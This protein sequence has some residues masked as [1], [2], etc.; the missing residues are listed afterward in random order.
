[1]DNHVH[2]QW[3]W[4]A[5]P[6]ASMVRSCE[7]ALAAGLPAVAFTDHLD[8]TV[9]AEGDRIAAEHISPR[10]Y[11]RMRLLDVPGYLAAVQECRERFGDLRILSGAEIG[12]AHLWEASA[13]AVAQ[14]AGFDRILG[15]LHAI[16]FDGRLTAAD[17]LFRRM[18]ADD[19]MRRYLAELLRLIEGSDLFQV[20]A[21]MD[22]PRRAW[23]RTA[24]P[25]DERGFEPEIRAVLRALA[26]SGR[27]LEVNTKSPQWSAE[28]LGWWRDSGGTAVSFGSDAHQYW[29]VGDR[30]K[31]AVDMAEAAGFRAGRDRF[32]FWRVYSRRRL[33]RPSAGRRSAPPP[34]ALRSRCRRSGRSCRPSFHRRGGARV[35]P[36]PD[37]QGRPGGQGETGFGCGRRGV[38]L[39]SRSRGRGLR[40][41]PRWGSRGQRQSSGRE[42]EPGS[43]PPRPVTGLHPHTCWPRPHLYAVAVS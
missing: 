38:A 39:R 30:F 37:P 2:T 16:P 12:E 9:A 13:Q 25:Y 7:Q 36:H 3:S 17:E 24:P 42:A 43:R 31:V 23:P 29:R 41:V 21:H 22:F 33:G 10:P 19:V 11:R 27:V 18:P 40:R 4:D 6:E 1:M 28:M 34:A 26:G 15:S 35:C 8:F 32:D 14:R 20:L 5:P